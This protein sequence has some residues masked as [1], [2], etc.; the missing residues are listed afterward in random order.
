MTD[1][2]HDELENDLDAAIDEIFESYDTD[3]SGSLE[4]EETTNF[5]NDLFASVGD[6]LNEDAHAKILAEVDQDG[7]GCLSKKELKDILA[8]AMED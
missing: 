1:I 2:T 6:K 8:K 3:R 5:F 4:K 7:D